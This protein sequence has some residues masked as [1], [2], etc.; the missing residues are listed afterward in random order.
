MAW[1]RLSR[2]RLP[3]VG[4][5][6]IRLAWVRLRIALGRIARWHLLRILSLHGLRV[7]RWVAHGHLLRVA[8]RWH[9]PRRIAGLLWVSRRHGGVTGGQTGIVGGCGCWRNGVRILA[10]GGRGR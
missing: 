7:S 3:W 6:G 4:L 1:V 9:H 10:H 2:I 8:L 5:T